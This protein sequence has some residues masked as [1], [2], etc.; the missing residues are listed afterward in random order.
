MI[1]DFGS[2]TLEKLGYVHVLTVFEESPFKL[3]NKLLNSE[4][5]IS[6]V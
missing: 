6:H 2:A 1:P 4:L 5:A 3:V